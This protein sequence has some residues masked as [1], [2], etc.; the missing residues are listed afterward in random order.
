MKREES[1]LQRRHRIR[2]T[3][4]RPVK[5]WRNPVFIV[6][7]FGVVVTAFL[8]T[9]PKAEILSRAEYRQSGKAVRIQLEGRGETKK[10]QGS[11]ILEGRSLT[12]SFSLAKE[13][14]VYEKGRFALWW[15][16]KKRYD[17]T[18]VGPWTVAIGQM[19]EKPDLEVFVGCYRQTKFFPEGPR[20][21]LFSWD[22]DKSELLRL[23]TGSYLNAPIFLRAN[24]EDYDGDGYEEIALLENSWQDD[25]EE[26]TFL[27]YYK[28]ERNR[29]QP[30]MVYRIEVKKDSQ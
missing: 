2:Q 27:S 7:L 29:F 11:G 1:F 13:L 17:F 30:Y 19:D 8:S 12:H 18:A 23:W 21:Y 9:R 22:S 3:E 24:F 16:E 28:Y 15:Q 10:W 4:I 25:A 14:V 26:K 5:I 6:I 20:P